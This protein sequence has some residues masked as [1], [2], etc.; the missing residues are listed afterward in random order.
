MHISLTFS[1]S[2]PAFLLLSLSLAALDYKFFQYYKKEGATVSKYFF[3]SFFLLVISLIIP[4]FVGLFLADKESA[5]KITVILSTLFQNLFCAILLYALLSQRLSKI[6][7]KAFFVLM[8]IFGIAVT[9]LAAS[10]PSHPF[11]ENGAFIN[12]NVD[13]TLG[14][15]RGALLFVALIPLSIVLIKQGFSKNISEKRIK[16]R[17]LGL[18]AIF[19]S[20][21]IFLGPLQF[22][23]QTIFKIGAASGD[24][25]S[26]IT[27]I[28]LFILIIF[29]Q[30]SPYPEKNNPRLPEF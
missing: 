20:A 9:F 3:Y 1:Y 24:I 15:L 4:A 6:A 17:T 29:T 8:L 10:R 13:P 22:F 25:S 14:A 7:S 2:G 11:L 27:S 18:A 16:V 21:A 12:W 30:K 28:A 23:I 5:L 19:L 26:V